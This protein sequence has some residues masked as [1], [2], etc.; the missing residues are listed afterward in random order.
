MSK[1]A[2][3]MGQGGLA[4]SLW[5]TCPA[6]YGVPCMR[7]PASAHS[8]MSPISHGFGNTTRSW[9]AVGTELHSTAGVGGGRAGGGGTGGGGDR[10]QG[11]HCR[12]GGSIAG[13]RASL[14]GH[15][16]RGAAHPRPGRE[17]APQARYRGRGR[18]SSRY[19]AERAAPQE[20][21]EAQ[22]EAPLGKD[23]GHARGREGCLA[24]GG[25]QPHG[26]MLLHEG[27][28][29]VSPL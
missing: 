28:E 8:E 11:Q 26:T 15:P 13:V 23:S 14:G 25:P 10:G 2:M 20:C 5:H 4:A 9:A 17:A 3:N 24:A 18:D 1:H 19:A 27:G 22:P 29:A 6:M 12:H 16:C 7:A 21:S